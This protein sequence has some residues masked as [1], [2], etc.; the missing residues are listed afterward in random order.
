MQSLIGKKA[1]V[2][3]GGTGIGRAIALDLSEAG[4]TVTV[5]GRRKEP[6]E[7]TVTLAEVSQGQ[8]MPWF[9]TLWN[10]MR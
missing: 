7:E 5:C 10:Q 4:A 8:W 3:G 2:T 1:L 9:V 6:L